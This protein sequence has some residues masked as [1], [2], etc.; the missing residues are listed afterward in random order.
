MMPGPE[1]EMAA[2]AADRGHLR[3]SHAD[4]S[5]VVD[6]LKAAFIEGR[7]TKDELDARLSQ[8]LAAR[9]YAELAV[10]TAD[11]PPGTKLARHPQPD[12]APEPQPAHWVAHSAVKSGG[13]AIG[14]IVLAITAIGVVVGQPLMGMIVAVFIV[15]LTAVASALVGSLVGVT[16]MLESR[17]RRKRSPGQ[18]AAGPGSGASGGAESQGPPSVGPFP[19]R[20]PGE[21]YAAEATRLRPRFARQA[22]V[23]LVARSA[24]YQAV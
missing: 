11:I 22:T 2:F 13:A 17:R 8:T 4:R 1:R 3:A 12:R 6:V 7:L 16:L 14:G 20:D 9:T 15:M 19:S 18:S 24:V 21:Q 5:R 10:L 23:M